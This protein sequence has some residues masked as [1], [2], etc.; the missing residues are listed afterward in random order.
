VTGPDLGLADAL[1][2][3][4]AVGGDEVLTLLKDV[5]GYEGFTIG[6]DGAWKWTNGFPFVHAPASN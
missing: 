3:A 5:E 6:H 4:L 1:A 2:T